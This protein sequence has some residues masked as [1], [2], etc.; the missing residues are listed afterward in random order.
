MHYTIV[1][2]EISVCKA[3]IQELC[4]FGKY[5]KLKIEEIKS[6]GMHESKKLAEV[7]PGSTRPDAFKMIRD[8]A[9]AAF[10]R[11][12]HIYQP[13]QVSDLHIGPIW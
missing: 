2:V 13:K 3:K 4:T 11:V 10:Q 8:R 1:K 6:R 9:K 12:T 7:D 5:L